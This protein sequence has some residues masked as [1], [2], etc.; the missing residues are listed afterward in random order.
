MMRLGTWEGR[1]LSIARDRYFWVGLS[2]DVED[3]LRCCPRCI[4]AKAPHLP[5]KAPLVSIATTRPLELVCIDFLGLEVSKGGYQY[6]L[7]VTD[8]FTK[9]AC[10]FPTRNQEAKTVA[11]VLMEEY[12][13]HYGVPERIHS[14]QG[15]SFEGKVIKHLCAMLGVNKSRTTPYHPEG[16]GITERFNRTLISMLKT[17]DPIDKVNW[18]SHLAPLVHAYNSTRHE[19]TGFSPFYL[20]FGRTPRL[21]MDVFQ[22]STI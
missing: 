18:K 19:L 7:V 15:G 9:Y 8:H 5:E 6:V 11:K 12:I 16:D 2:K 10:A 21:S 14:D 13:V 17:L 1:R 4:R 3:K 20:M 22:K